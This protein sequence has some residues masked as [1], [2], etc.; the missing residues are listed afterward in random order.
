MIRPWLRQLDARAR[1]LLPLTSAVAAVLLDLLPLPAAG[2]GVVSSFVTLCVVYF[3][4]LYRPD[5]FT[6]SAAFVTGLIYDGLTGLPLGVTSL[7][8]L[9]V[10]S[11]MVTQ[12]RFFIARAFPVIWACFLVLAPIALLA[13][14]L[15][16]SLWWGHLFAL[17]PLAVE[18]ALTV[19][20]YP[21]ASWVLGRIHN[22]IPRLIYAP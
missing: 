20:L 13:R 12:Q 6:P 18:L 8:L 3:W 14:W 21:L 9:L 5:L 15:V 1:S 2:Q 7:M 19:M 17:P 10:R 22:R 16:V 11:L 4:S